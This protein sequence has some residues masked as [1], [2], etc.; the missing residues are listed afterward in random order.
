[1]SDHDF[2]SE[3]ER[4]QE[5][6]D[7]AGHSWKGKIGRFSGGGE[8]MAG[9]IGRDSLKAPRQQWFEQLPRVC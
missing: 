1:M 9:Q 4:V 5:S 8:T 7:G 2:G 6:R 3:V